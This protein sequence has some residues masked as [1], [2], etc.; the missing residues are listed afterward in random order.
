MGMV[1]LRALIHLSGLV[2]YAHFKDCDPITAPHGSP[3]PSSVVVTYVLVVLT[4]IPGLSGLFVAA[5]Y[6]AVLS[7]V[8]TQLNSMTALLWED[9]LKVMPV[10]KNWSEVK[11][12][13]LQK[14]LVFAAGVLGIILGLAV[15]QLGRSFLRALFAINGALSGPLIGLF[16]TAVYLPW[17]NA[18]GAST[19]FV[20][21]IILNIWIVIGQL[22]QPKA[23]Y[24]PLSRDGC[25]NINTMT[26]TPLN[27]TITTTVAP[28]TTLVSHSTLPEEEMIHPLYGLSYCL[29]S[30]WGTLFCIVVAVIVTAI[31]GSNSP[32]DVEE[33]LVSPQ[34]WTLF[35]K[36]LIIQGKEFFFKTIL[37]RPS[38]VRDE[39]ERKAE[40]IEVKDPL[41][42]SLE[43]KEHLDNDIISRGAV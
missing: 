16:L 11:I 3:D 19:G 15:S 30:L 33:N 39:S 40:D 23:E 13:G 6:A 17:V 2:M 8:S 4:K 43:S 26:S 41:H 27:L 10:F 12:G 25:P 5:I 31:T 20:V 35:Q 28:N 24:L 29:N 42:S 21:A 7:S 38:S 36:S 9:F 32:D 1:F 18:K 34:S 37:R 14:V 22:T